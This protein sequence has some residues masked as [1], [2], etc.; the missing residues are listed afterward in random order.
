V[1]KS[2][3]LNTLVGSHQLARASSTPGRT[4]ALNWF[5]IEPPKGPTLAFVD[6]PGY[7]Y[8]RVPNEM[9]ASWKP[10]VTAFVERPSLRL[11]VLLVDLRRGPELEELELLDWLDK[12]GVP[13]LVVLTKSDKLGKA[14]RGA[15]AIAAAKAAGRPVKGPAAPLVVSAHTADGMPELWRAI[16]ARIG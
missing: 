10:L 14:Q 4:R 12:L 13:Q 3:L 1:G 2:S 15:A 6:L 11:V 7:G 16:M 5:E 9:Q 8:A